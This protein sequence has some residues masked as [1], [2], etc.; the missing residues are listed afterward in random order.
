MILLTGGAGF[1]GSHTA[2]ELLNIG[3]D[4]V[5]VDN[6]SNSKPEILTGIRKITG[7]DFPSRT[8]DIANY[9]DLNSVFCEF[10]IDSVI[11]FAGFKSVAESVK[12]PIKYYRNNLDGT[13]TLLEVMITHNVTQIVFSS[14]AAVYGVSNVVPIKEDNHVGLCT[15][16]YGRT[17]YFIEQI[18]QDIVTARPEMSVVLLR[19]FNP[20]GA[21]TSALI[22][23]LPVSVPNNLMPYITQT[24]AGKHP[25]L[26]VFGNDY[27]TRDGTGVRDYIHIVDLA[28]GH[29][30][31][32]LYAQNHRGIEIFNLGT[33]IGYSVLEVV[34]AFE[35]A[36][37]ISIPLAFYP[38]RAGDV[39]ECWACVDKV[40]KFLKWQATRSLDDMCAD[41]WRWQMHID[42]NM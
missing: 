11:H 24:A 28:K 30:A 31:A 15:N 6:F 20:V 38:R 14:S 33:G 39:P 27:S 36:T 19:Y 41:A 5:I 29:I 18:L 12:D 13:L 34:D 2:V 25:Y 8:I 26:K 3:R 9:D 37:G 22:G 35:H 23:E 40:R 1:I 16:P 4:I 7:K 10:N 21:H 32:L 42:N 17:K